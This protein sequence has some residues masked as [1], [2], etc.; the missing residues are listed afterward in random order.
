MS[1]AKQTPLTDLLRRV[2]RDM[3]VLHESPDQQGAMN[4]AVGPL[5]HVAADEIERLRA[6]N[7]AL[8]GEVQ[9]RRQYVEGYDERY[10]KLEAD[11]DRLRAAL[12]AAMEI[13][14]Q[15]RMQ[16]YYSCACPVTGKP[17]PED[18][19]ALARYD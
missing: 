8:S 13:V 6:E 5:M 17:S 19:V 10:T 4:T 11:N 2:P 12:K 9:R 1:D 18:D 3:S 15:D 14:Q 16:L 7:A